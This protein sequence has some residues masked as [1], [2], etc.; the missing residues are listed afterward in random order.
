M[1]F[2][3]TEEQRGAYWKWA[4]EYYTKNPDL[5]SSDKRYPTVEKA[6]EAIKSGAPL[7]AN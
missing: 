4:K 6:L 7:P 1:D 3:L 5:R 2:S